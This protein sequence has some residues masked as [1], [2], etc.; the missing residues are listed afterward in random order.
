MQEKIILL[1]NYK[2]EKRLWFNNIEW[3]VILK[4][5]LDSIIFELINVRSF[6]YFTNKFYFGF[7]REKYNK[8]NIKSIFDM[9]VKSIEGKNYR[10]IE[11]KDCIDFI[12]DSVK[13]N[14][15]KKENNEN[16]INSFYKE[17]IYK[18]RKEIQNKNA[19]INKLNGKIKLLENKK[20]KEKVKEKIVNSKKTKKPNNY[21]KA[22]YLIKKE[23]INKKINILNYNQNKKEKISEFC[24]IYFN[25]KK[26]NFTYE[27]NFKKEGEYSF[28]F[29]FNK[30]LT[31]S[32]YL[33]NKCSNL[34]SIDLSNFN[35]EEITNMKSMFSECKLLKN[36]D[37]SNFKTDKVINMNS[38]FS[39]CS[40]LEYLDLSNFNT[41]NVE[42]IGYMFCCCSSLKTLN[43]SSFNTKKVYIL[44]ALFVKINSNINIIT[45]DI[46]I[47]N[48]IQC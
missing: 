25:E 36:I 47:L 12:L 6:K 27:Y 21:I 9:I 30:K 11:N 45:N 2:I 34:I 7:L 17:E 29:L 19:E 38:M 33:F 18:L 46:K 8:N 43:L 32:S 31:D 48:K 4:L 42:D 28:T 1:S 15:I 5:D 20:E 16:E 14:I 10:I 23:D 24:E 35:S 13:F 44:D 41:N 40:S 26:I 22:V 37:L 39:D 3:K